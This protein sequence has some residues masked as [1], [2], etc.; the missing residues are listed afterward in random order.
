LRRIMGRLVIVA[1]VAGGSAF[2]V[3]N[4]GVVKA[5]YEDLYPRDPARRQA[6]ELCFT[7]DHKFN[8]LEA[9]EREACYRRMLPTLGD[10]PPPGGVPQ[11]PNTNLVDLERA[12]YAGSMPRNDIRRLEQ[13]QNTLHQPR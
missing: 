11:Q 4:P 12:A 10:I 5:F 13:V 3:M 1:A 6:L 8:R 7:Q 9:S 2:A